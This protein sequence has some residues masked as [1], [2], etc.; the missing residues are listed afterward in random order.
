MTSSTTTSTHHLDEE[1]ADGFSPTGEGRERTIKTR[2][3]IAATA[4]N[5]AHTSD[6]LDMAGSL[7]S[8]QSGPRYQLVADEDW[9]VQSKLTP[10]RAARA[11]CGL[12]AIG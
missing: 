2:H 10:G 6:D 11:F 9:A 7:R 5:I 12:A 4:T 3:P 1:S 8:A